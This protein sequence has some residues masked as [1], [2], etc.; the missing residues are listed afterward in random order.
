MEL[1][2]LK[3]AWKAVPEKNTYKQKDIFEMM[4][5]KSS[6][7]IKWLFIFTSAEFLLVLLFTT[8]TI[9]TEKIFA[10]NQ[11]I[12]QLG[13]N[14]Y[15]VGSTI[16]IIITFSFLYI[17]YNTYKKI[18]INNSI[19]GLVHQI[20]RFRKMVNLFILIILFSLI[21]ISIPYYYQL[22]QDIYVNKI[23]IDYDVEKAKLIGYI[24]VFIAIIFLIIITSIYY[25]II[26]FLFIKKLEKNLNQLKEVN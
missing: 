24:S 25:S 6:S 5:K 23:G 1:D 11:P 22:G 12:N 7:I 21:I 2:D 3:S 8:Y 26:Y 14:N 15:L 17:I 16:T 20:I 18:N 9:S 13:Q 4:K 19:S 10:N